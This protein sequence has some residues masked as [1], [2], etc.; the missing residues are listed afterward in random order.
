MTIMKHQK[1]SIFA[2]SFLLCL[3]GNAFAESIAIKH[4]QIFIADK[5]LVV[6]NLLNGQLNQC[7][8]P[9]LLD[10]AGNDVTNLLATATDIVVKRNL[11]VITVHPVDSQGNASTD[12][13][14]VDVSKCLEQK[15]IPV[16]EC[17]S[18]VDL[19]RG[20][21]TIPCV[22]INDSIVTVNMDRRG[23]SSNWEVTFFQNNSNMANY[24]ED[25]DD[26]DD[27]DDD[28]K[29]NKSEQKQR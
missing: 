21:L 17:I 13:V 28:E 12:T 19:D 3:C 15:T 18:T 20:V 14:T 2:A 7:T 23:N 27:D 8:A 9:P 1:F 5:G 22:K 29:T 6:K 26:D 4:D 16:K 25:D 10:P 11:A 24:S